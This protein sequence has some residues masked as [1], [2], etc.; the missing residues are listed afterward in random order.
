MGTAAFNCSELELHY[1]GGT[2][3]GPLTI[4]IPVGTCVALVGENGAGKSSLINMMLGLRPWDKGEAKLFDISA[5]KPGARSG[6]GYLQEVVDFPAKTNAKELMQ[7]HSKL[8]GI[9]GTMNVTELENYLEGFGLELTAKPIKNYSKGMKQRLALAISMLD[10]K[11]MLILDEPNSGL[12]PVGIAMLRS[13]L[14]QLKAGGTTLLISTH[15][16]AEVMAIADEVLV[17]HKGKVA[18]SSSMSEFP[19]FPAFEKYFLDRVK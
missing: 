8:A 4:E 9:E 12:D 13:K 17:I 19:D 2:K 15:R 6:I 16:L 18:G 3:I 10:C 11:R 7:L 1:Q 5:E 14:D